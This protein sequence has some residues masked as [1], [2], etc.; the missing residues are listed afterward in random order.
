M[1]G[2][3]SPYGTISRGDSSRRR[4][5]RRDDT[6]RTI[7]AVVLV[8]VLVLLIGFLGVNA[9][10]GNESTNK[11]NETNSGEEINQNGTQDSTEGETPEATEEQTP[12]QTEEPTEPPYVPETVT[13]EH[14]VWLDAGHGGD[15]WGS[16]E[17]VRN[18]AGQI[19]DANGKATT[20]EA[21]DGQWVVREKHDTLDLSLLIQQE[22]E[23]RGVTVIMTRTD[24]TYV[25]R[26]DR[27]AQANESGAECFVSIHRN[28]ML[29][30][31]EQCGIEAWLVNEITRAEKPGKEK[32]E[33]L[34]GFIFDE[35]TALGDKTNGILG[36]FKETDPTQDISVLFRTN[37]PAVLLEMGYMSN[38]SDNEKYELYMQDY[39]VAIAD[40][41]VQWL[42]TQE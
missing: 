17:W 11:D 34:T 8:C 28:Y 31:R 26:F 41:I 16:A 1:A 27:A 21:A 20:E 19:I 32:D 15:D 5:K 42:K 22:L 23:A 6:I 10:K 30:D 3:H 12:E 4:R 29:G 18:E 9:L 13:K 39:A 37:M 36:I 2:N 35:L 7:L 24:D 25:H 40:G 38:D 33:D 14:I